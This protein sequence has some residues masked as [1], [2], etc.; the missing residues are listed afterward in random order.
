VV[1]SEPTFR[2]NLSVRNW[3][4]LP[5][6]MRPI[7]C[8]ETSVNKL[9]T[10]CCVISQKSA[11]LTYFAAGNEIERDMTKLKKKGANRTLPDTTIYIL[12]YS[13]TNVMHFL[14][15]LLRLKGLYMFRALLAHPQEALHNR[16]LVYCVR[17]TLVVYTNLCRQLTSHTRNIPR[18]VCV[19]TPE[20]EQVMFQRRRRP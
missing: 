11:D 17:A 9:P 14:F 7:C 15:N 2:D 1:I 13:E 4:S 18:T 8:P 12:L 16:H 10:I 5:L 20:D 19:A 6:K 3:I